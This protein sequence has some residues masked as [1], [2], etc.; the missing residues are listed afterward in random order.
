[1]KVRGHAL[2]QK[3]IAAGPEFEGVQLL[4][5][6]KELLVRELTWRFQSLHL[7]GWLQSSGV[8]LCRFH[9][10]SPFADALLRASQTGGASYR[11]EHPASRGGAVGKTA[12]HV[13]R[14]GVGAQALKGIAH[15]AL[16]RV[17]P[18]ASRLIASRGG[19]NTR[20]APGSWWF[21]ST[22]RTFTNIGLA[23]EPVLDHPL[24]YL[25]E[26]SETGGQPLHERRRTGHLLYS[27]A[28]FSDLP[29]S[30]E[31]ERIADQ[32]VHGLQ[33]IKLEREDAAA[34]DLLL[35]GE[36]FQGFLSRTLRLA[37]FQ[38]RALR[39]WLDREQPSLLV[40]GNA[41]WENLVLQQA[42]ARGIPT[43]LLQH[44]ILGDYYQLMDF[45]VDAILVRGPFFYD[46]LSAEARRRAHVLN[47]PVPTKTVLAQ[48]AGRELLFLTAPYGGVL[49]HE[50]DL[51]EILSA[52][53][54]AAARAN[55]TLI[56]RVHPLES[57]T[58]YQRLLERLCSQLQL[59][60]QVEYSQGPGL[61]D[62]LLRSAV[63]VTRF[64]TTFLDCLRFGVP[65][66]SFGWQDFSLRP[67]L[68]SR[69][70]LHLA[71]DLAHLGALIDQ[72][73]AGRLPS[74]SET[75]SQFLADTTAEEIQQFFS[76]LATGRGL[77][78]GRGLVTGRGQAPAR[79]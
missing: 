43:V 52:A 27:Y 3:L 16:R 9:S 42:Q 30:K 59:H 62:L 79:S 2:A 6:M 54:S 44:G 40:V 50:K 25:Y 77:E 23:Y 46:F 34:R 47:L 38:A 26:D 14:E 11:V 45:P 41:A 5:A 78:T 49:M 12:E 75:I 31:V 74:R 22:A 48:T 69:N 57:V 71:A 33:R 1:M 19:R 67:L 36:W 70:V 72:A 21:Y 64:S 24:N 18:C 28:D 17:A 13:R 63:A 66:I 8:E 73:F 56:V 65:V 10:N 60:P 15:R 4:A 29:R 39:H 20:V 53:I 32:M 76:G 51:E 7:D 68:D 35:Q 55:R 61:E 58:F 37:M